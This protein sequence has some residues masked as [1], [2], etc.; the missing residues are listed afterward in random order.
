MLSRVGPGNMYYMGMV[1]TPRDWH[2]FGVS[3]QLESI[4]KY[5]IW[6]MMAKRVSCAKKN[7]WTDLNDP[8]VV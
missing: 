5:R 4:V 1:M 8:Y 6:G 7:K 2:F 3:G